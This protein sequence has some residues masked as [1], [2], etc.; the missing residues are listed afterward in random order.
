MTMIH[1]T[2]GETQGRR[3]ESLFRQLLAVVA[4]TTIL[5]NASLIFAGTPKTP[6]PDVVKAKVEKLGVG[7]HVMVK[8]T[9]GPKLHGHITGIAE[10]SF[11]LHPDNARAE[12]EIPYSDV[13]KIHKNPG[14]ITWMLVGA[15]LVIIVIIATR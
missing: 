8:R 15:A 13:L 14:P 2:G 10:Q 7:E 4:A 1:S 12:V 11:K 6:N 3:H 9:E 5:G